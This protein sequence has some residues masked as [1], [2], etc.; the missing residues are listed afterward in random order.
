ME[1]ETYRL[2]HHKEFLKQQKRNSN[3]KEILYWKVP[4]DV[5]A[6]INSLLL[7]FL[8]FDKDEQ[9]EVDKRLKEPKRW[10]CIYLVQAC[11]LRMSLFKILLVGEQSQAQCTCNARQQNE[12]MFSVLVNRVTHKEIFNNGLRSEECVKLWNH[13]ISWLLSWMPFIHTYITGHYNPSVRISV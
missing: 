3:S 13:N 11:D 8:L 6:C 2:P 9:D 1:I 10:K 7:L 4:V 12:L 5:D